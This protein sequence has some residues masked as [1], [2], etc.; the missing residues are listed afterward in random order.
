MSGGSLNYLCFSEPNDLIN[1]ID[2]MEEVEAELFN[3]GYKDIAK[4]VRRLIEYVLSAHNRIS[5]LQENLNDVFHAVE[6]YRS[7]D[8]GEDSLLK[9]FEEYRKKE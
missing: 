8:I 5:V 3:R 1:K 2:D 4:D 6:W 7:A 9:A